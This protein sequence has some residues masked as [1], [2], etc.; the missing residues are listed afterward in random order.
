MKQSVKIRFTKK[1]TNTLVNFHENK[2]NFIPNN[3]RK[4]FSKHLSDEEANSEY[5]SNYMHVTSVNKHPV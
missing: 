2:F 4:F 5:D 1:R 3:S